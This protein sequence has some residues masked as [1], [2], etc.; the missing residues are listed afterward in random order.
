M[1]TLDRMSLDEL[2]NWK[3][4][5]PDTTTIREMVS[6]I[7]AA[8][9]PDRVLL[10]GSHARGEA[11]ETSDVDFLVIK[12]TDEPRPKRSVPLY[13]AVRDYPCAVDIVVLTPTELQE[14]AETPGTLAYNALHEGK[15][16]YEREE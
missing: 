15:V 8:C 7:V 10:I 4:E 11:T 2:R 3:P 13:A 6:R 1:R 14:F 16:V 12:D 5:K 9:G